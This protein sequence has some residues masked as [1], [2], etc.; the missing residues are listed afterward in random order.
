MAVLVYLYSKAQAVKNISFNLSVP[1]RFKFDGFAI[2][3]EQGLEA[4]NGDSLGVTIS[5]LASKIYHIDTINGKSINTEI[6][7]VNLIQSTKIQGNALTTLPLRVRI[8]VTNLGSLI[9]GTI[10]DIK[11]RLLR[12]R[13]TGTVRGESVQLPFDETFSYVI[14]SF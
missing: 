11:N 14:P 13:I 3:W 7:T 4:D 12:F 2:G 8:P 10:D 9:A 6:G 5:G 1:K